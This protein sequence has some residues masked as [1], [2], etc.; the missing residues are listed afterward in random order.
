MPDEK[1]AAGGYPGEHIVRFGFMPHDPICRTSAALM[2]LCWQ[3]NARKC[4]A[5]HG[6]VARPDKVYNMLVCWPQ[7]LMIWPTCG[8]HSMS[9]NTLGSIP[10]WYLQAAASMPLVFS[11]PLYRC[12]SQHLLSVC[13]RLHLSVCWPMF[14]GILQVLPLLQRC[15][16]SGQGHREGADVRGVGGGPQRRT[17]GA[18]RQAAV[19][20]LHQFWAWWTN[21]LIR[22]CRGSSGSF[23]VMGLRRE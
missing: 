18:V 9:L 5:A 10:S 20:S 14:Q 12:E 6:T 8:A 11:A 19:N 22:C 7:V 23:V 3:R 4:T 1:A 13:A 16:P 21:S 15:A 17:S 2:S